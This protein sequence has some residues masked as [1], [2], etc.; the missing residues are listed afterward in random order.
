MFLASANSTIQLG[1]PDEVRGRVMSMWVL[2]F[3]VGMPI[4]SLIAGYVARQIGTP[5]TLL[6]QG[7]GSIPAILLA[8]YVLTRFDRD[9]LTASA[10]N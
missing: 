6:L 2:T 1:V 4:G 5:H 9:E 3:G 8:A 10:G 7:I